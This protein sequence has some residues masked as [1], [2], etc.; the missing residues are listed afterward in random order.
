MYAMHFGCNYSFKSVFPYSCCC[1]KLAKGA[2]SVACNLFNQNDHP[3]IEKN[4]RSVPAHYRKRPV[5]RKLEKYRRVVISAR[6]IGVFFGV[7]IYSYKLNIVY[8]YR[9]SFFFPS[10][11]ITVVTGLYYTSLLS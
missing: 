8:R 2:K 3:H 9:I 4:G 1:K 10:T 7:F 11:N 6:Y 5:S